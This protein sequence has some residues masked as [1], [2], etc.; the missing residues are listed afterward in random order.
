MVRPIGVMQRHT[1][2]IKVQDLTP[3]S[4]LIWE[5]VKL[6]TW[7]RALLKKVKLIL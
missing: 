7:D 2:T 5:S 3:Y 4:P 6:A 1:L